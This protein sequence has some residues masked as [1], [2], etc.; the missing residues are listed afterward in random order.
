MSQSKLYV[1]CLGTTA[2]FSKTLENVSQTCG[3]NPGY[4]WKFI[5]CFWNLIPCCVLNHIILDIF[6]WR[7]IFEWHSSKRKCGNIVFIQCLTFG[8]VWLLYTKSVCDAICSSYAWFDGSRRS[9]VSVQFR[10]DGLDAAGLLTLPG[11]VDATVCILKYRSIV[12]DCHYL[13]MRL[14]RSNAFWNSD[15]ICLFVNIS[16][17]CWNLFNFVSFSRFTIFSPIQHFMCPNFKF[18]FTTNLSRPSSQSFNLL[19]LPSPTFNQP[20]RI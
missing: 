20:I 8:A 13:C 6:Q 15:I 4:S 17:V 3:K 12:G 9:D 5:L 19:Q 7:I 14:S 10:A 1:A 18:Q 2:I 16:N 11:T